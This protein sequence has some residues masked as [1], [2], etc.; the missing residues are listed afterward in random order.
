MEIL[1]FRDNGGIDTLWVLNNVFMKISA[2]F[3][4]IILEK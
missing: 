3:S 1:L 2:L 4:S